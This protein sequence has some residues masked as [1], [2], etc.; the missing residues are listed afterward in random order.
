ME[1]VCCIDSAF[2]DEDNDSETDGAVHAIVG[3]GV[4][5]AVGAVGGTVPLML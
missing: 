2:G 1:G 4:D 5:E 3:D